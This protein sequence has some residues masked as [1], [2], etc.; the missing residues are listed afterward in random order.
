MYDVIRPP[1]E[2][3]EVIDTYPQY[4]RGYAYALYDHFAKIKVNKY[5]EL[6]F[7]QYRKLPMIVR[8]AIWAN[9][10]DVKYGV[11]LDDAILELF[12]KYDVTIRSV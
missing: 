1:P 4:H 3:R 10:I 6:D 5:F 7:F 9:I 11:A 2:I 12:K 8:D